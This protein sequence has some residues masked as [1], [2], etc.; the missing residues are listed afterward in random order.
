MTVV[1]LLLSGLAL[2]TLLAAPLRSQQVRAPAEEPI[3]VV[4]PEVSR[5]VDVAAGRVGQRQNRDTAAMEVTGQP[6]A[7]I[8]NRIANRVQ[9]RL[10]NRIDQNY[11]PQA[12]AASPFRVAGDRA[13][14]PT[15]AVRR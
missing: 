12:N 5:T 2:T 1:R 11:D 9:S 8:S 3:P 13:R 14:S 7:R 10:R 15:G 4:A 6:M